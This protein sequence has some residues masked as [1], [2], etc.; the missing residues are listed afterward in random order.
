[1]DMLAGFIREQPLHDLYVHWQAQSRSGRELP[2]RGGMDV[3]DLPKTVIPHAFIYEREQ[4]GR[5]RCRLAGT[6]FTDDLGY[7][8]TGAYLDTKLHSELGRRRLALYADCIAAPRAIYFRA[9]MTPIGQEFRESGRLM[10]PV[11]DDSGVARFVFGGMVVA[12]LSSTSTVN[13]DPD[14]II[15]THLDSPIDHRADR[16]CG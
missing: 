14:G 16:V 11:A 5:F 6:R 13:V 7:E 2:G 10:L 9:R 15:E 4:D 8:P 3:L 12:L 1:M